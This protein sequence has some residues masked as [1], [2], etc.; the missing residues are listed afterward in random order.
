MAEK[1]FQDSLAICRQIGDR[2]SEV[3]L[4]NRLGTG[5]YYS[6]DLDSAVHHFQE[7][8]Q[9]LESEIDDQQ[10]SVEVFSNLGSALRDQ[11]DLTNAC[12][13]Y[14][15]ALNLSQQIEDYGGQADILLN[16]AAALFALGE[17]NE[18]LEQCEQALQ[19]YRKNEEH[20]GELLCLSDLAG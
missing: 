4:M 8:L 1:C 16:F 14:R 11:G 18:G 5:Y 6:G 3:R 7:S 17:S 20:Y 15:L 13:S 2:H 10:L 9:I 12:N 19:I